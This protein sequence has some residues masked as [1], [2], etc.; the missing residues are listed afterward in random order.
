MTFTNTIV[1]KNSSGTLEVFVIGSDHQVYHRW[2]KPSE[3]DGWAP[4][5][6]L[7]GSMA[8]LV[9]A[10]NADGRLELFG[11]G[12]NGALWHN[13]QKPTSGWSGWASLGNP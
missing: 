5:N 6:N 11:T 10:Q 8:S 9:G 2:Q 1:L 4:W 13:W 3:P 7:G 12:T